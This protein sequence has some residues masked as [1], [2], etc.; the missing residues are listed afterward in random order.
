MDKIAI[1]DDDDGGYWVVEFKEY[2][3]NQYGQ[4]IPIYKRKEYYHDLET[5]LKES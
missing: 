4:D 2:I 3:Q 5:A 1:F